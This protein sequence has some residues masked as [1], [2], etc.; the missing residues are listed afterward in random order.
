L[1]TLKI[2]I[3][4][5]NQN[6]TLLKTRDIAVATS[7]VPIKKIKNPLKTIKGMKT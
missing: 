1:L 3:I 6:T 4:K 7:I 2:K 5:N